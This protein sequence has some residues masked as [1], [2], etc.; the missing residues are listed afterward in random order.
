MPSP[1]DAR[2][3]RRE[4]CL[5]YT[6]KQKYRHDRSCR[7]HYAIRGWVTP[8]HFAPACVGWRRRLG[9]RPYGAAFEPRPRGG[10]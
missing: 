1:P 8:D 5:L 3:G 4:Q 10:D 7:H 2:E 6:G 9:K